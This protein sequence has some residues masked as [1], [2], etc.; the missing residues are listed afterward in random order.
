MVNLS[1]IS[2]CLASFTLIVLIVSS[3]LSISF[4]VKRIKKSF[5]D[6]IPI[7]QDHRLLFSLSSS[8]EINSLPLT[9]GQYYI[10]KD[11]E[12]TVGIL[13]VEFQF[14]SIKSKR[15]ASIT[16][17]KGK[18]LYPQISNLNYRALLDSFSVPSG[19]QCKEGYHQCGILDT[20][21]NVLCL[22]S[23]QPC[24]INDIIMT[25]TN[26]VPDSFGNYSSYDMVQFD[27]RSFLYYTNEAVDRPVVVDFVI[28]KEY[29]CVYDN[30]KECKEEDKDPRLILLDEM[31]LSSLYYTNQLD[32]VDDECKTLVDLT[33]NIKLFYREFIGYDTQCMKDNKNFWEKSKF[34]DNYLIVIIIAPCIHIPI[35]V[36]I[37]LPIVKYFRSKGE[38][39][40]DFSSKE[41]S[42]VVWIIVGISVFCLLF[43]L[44]LKG[45]EGCSDQYT[46][47]LVKHV[48][49]RKKKNDI[50]LIVIVVINGVSLI[51]YTIYFKLKKN[52]RK[53]EEKEA[54]QI[55]NV[56][57]TKY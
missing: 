35:I 17:W 52:Q 54:N 23:D 55:V 33:G 4:V 15:K 56:Q 34:F 9:F 57:Q 44:V 1:V 41:I 31:P 25:H 22:E 19:Q 42:I 10:T 37:I 5:L 43:S 13:L 27:E 32:S 51:L 26:S 39:D 12:L 16:Q 30:M 50:L 36:D 24:P 21:G 29:P 2:F 14:S 40:F 11:T 28:N 46:D 8:N 38:E 49:N 20:L 3:A 45:I 6:D 53:K 7:N 18:S 47:R 48:L